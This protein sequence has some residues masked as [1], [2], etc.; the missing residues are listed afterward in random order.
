MKTR[1]TKRAARQ[2]GAACS[3]WL[4]AKVFTA[5]IGLEIKCPNCGTFAN[6]INILKTCSRCGA[7]WRKAHG[8]D[9]Y[10]FLCRSN[11]SH[12]A[13]ATEGRR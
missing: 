9:N 10:E 12:H 8:G 2:G 7:P 3:A 5:S 1:K 13:E 6:T 11:A 4:S